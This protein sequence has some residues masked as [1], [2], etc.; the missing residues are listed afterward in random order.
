M[1]KIVLSK[2]L[3][4]FHAI[5]LNVYALHIDTFEAHTF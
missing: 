2:R 1:K 3:V 4:G 5:F